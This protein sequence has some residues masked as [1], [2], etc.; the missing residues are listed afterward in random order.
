MKNYKDKKNIC[1]YVILFCKKKTRMNNKNM[2]PNLNIMCIKDELRLWGEKRNYNRAM[3]AVY[4]LLFLMYSDF[5]T[6][7]VENC[8][9]KAGC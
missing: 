7:V 3:Y 6:C 9:K 2:L 4:S 8:M 5:N 1:K